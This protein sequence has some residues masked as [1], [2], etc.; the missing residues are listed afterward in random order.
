MTRKNRK[1][2][3]EIAK[4]Q[5]KLGKSFLL[6]LIGLIGVVGGSQLVVNSA[7][8]IAAAIGISDRIIA[9]SVVALGTSLP[10]LITTVTAAR[11]NEHELLVGNIVGSNI[12]NICIVLGLP[13]VIFGTITPE[14]FEIIDIAMLIGSAVILW[15]VTLTSSKITRKEGALMLL[16]FAIYYGYLVYGALA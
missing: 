6:V 10:E 1:S 16:I 13:V 3:N 14:S 7:S 2:K 12:F 11:R 15:L 5:Y 9:L 4:P 8:T